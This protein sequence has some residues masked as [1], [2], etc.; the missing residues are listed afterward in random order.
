MHKNSASITPLPSKSD[1]GNS[2]VQ[3][4][5]LAGASQCQWQGHTSNG[6]QW[7]GTLFPSLP[8]NNN[9][10]ATHAR[11]KD[12]RGRLSIRRHAITSASFVKQA[13]SSLAS[14]PHSPI[15][16]RRR[17]CCGHRPR[18]ILCSR[19]SC[20]STEDLQTA[21]LLGPCRPGPAPS[22]IALWMNP[23]YRYARLGIRLRFAGVRL[24]GLRLSSRLHTVAQSRPCFNHACASHGSPCH[25]NW[26]DRVIRSSL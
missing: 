20:T 18:S 8:N 9:N 5:S 3:Q 15:G 1:G 10:S 26:N 23:L 24:G 6:V 17:I 22:P 2:T 14:C 7:Y 19:S 11:H 25:V 13:K 4:S 12:K 21:L 16:D